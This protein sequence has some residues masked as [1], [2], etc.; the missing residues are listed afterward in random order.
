MTPAAVVAWRKHLKLTQTD[1]AQLL[2]VDIRTVQRW[3][4]GDTRVSQMAQNLMDKI[5]TQWA[6]S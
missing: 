5:S 4:A 2:G 1:V 6:S 3:E